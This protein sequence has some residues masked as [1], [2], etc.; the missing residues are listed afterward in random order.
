MG[1][2]ISGVGI[3]SWLDMQKGIWKGSLCIYCGAIIKA[4]HSYTEGMR[5]GRYC[6]N[7]GIEITRGAWDLA[8]AF[9][10]SICPSPNAC[11]KTR[12]MFWNCRQVPFPS[13]QLIV[14]SLK[15]KGVLSEIKF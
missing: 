8:L 1:F 6:P 9:P 12:A 2:G 11:S 14:K 13:W 3:T 15:P 10:G 7:C 5:S 4:S